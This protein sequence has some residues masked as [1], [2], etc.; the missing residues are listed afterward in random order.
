VGAEELT[1]ALFAVL[2]ILK[3]TAPDDS[4]DRGSLMVLHSLACA[5]PMRLSDAAQLVGLDLST[6]SRHVRTLENGGYVRR[7]EDPKDRRASLLALT[8]DGEAFL[9]RLF[10]SRRAS[11][12]AATAEW[13]DED[14]RTLTQLLNRLAED[15]EPRATRP[16]SS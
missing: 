13:P 2:R 3:R 6:V 4:I 9:Q 1:T 7:A 15:L 16:E 11:F 5:E 12:D 10:E 8:A 14:R